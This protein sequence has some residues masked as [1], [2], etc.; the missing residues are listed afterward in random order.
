MTT[1]EYNLPNNG[2]FLTVSQIIK[3]VMMSAA[4]AE[5]GAL[6][7]NTR[8]AIPTRNT[9]HEMGHPRPPT[10]M[11]TDN[12]TALG[13]VTN[14]LQPKAT[15]STDMQHWFMRNRQYQIQFKYYWGSG[16]FNDG[17]YHTKNFCSAHHREKRL[18]YLTPCSVLDALRTILGQEPHKY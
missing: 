5:I 8:H 18:R 6:Y 12:T 3:N 2:A 14:N 16:N 10:P 7:I 11:Q 15:K 9:L 13:F 1:N 17:D 4:D